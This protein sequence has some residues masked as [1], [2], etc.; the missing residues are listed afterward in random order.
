MKDKVVFLPGLNGL[1]AIAAIAVVI[2]HTT[3]AIQ[4]FGVNFSLFGN[5]AEGKPKGYL[6]ALALKQKKLLL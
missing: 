4:S 5:D 2:S 3:L 6:L 1:R